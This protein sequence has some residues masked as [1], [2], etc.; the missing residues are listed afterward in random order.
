MVTTDVAARAPSSGAAGRTGRAAIA[1]SVVALG[2]WALLLV[3]ARLWG[4]ALLDDGHV[5]RLGAPPLVGWDDWRPS[6]RLLAP[7][8]AAALVV[9]V[10]PRL[11]SRR[12]WRVV[13][14]GAVAATAL[15]A[16]AL[17]LVDG[18]EGIT[19][20]LVLPGD[21]Y[22]LD[23]PSVGS[24]GDFL[25]SFTDEIDGY[26][27]HVRSHPPGML[28]L[29]WSM[30]RIGLGGTGWAAVLC[31]GGG[32]MAVAAVLVAL[33]D[34]AGER[35]ARAAAPFVVL[36]PAALWIATTADA[37]FAGVGAWAVTLLVLATGR[38]DGRG[39]L[40]A[41]G[42]GLLFG[43]ALM[44]SY[45]L[46]LLALL[47]GAVALHRRRVRPLV[48]GAVAA[49]AVLAAF[50]VAGFWW[51]E[52]L[53]VTRREYLESVARTR[54][55]RYFVVANL[56]AF[57]L[58]LGPAVAVG[59]ARLREARVWLLVGAALV[60]VVVADLSGMSKGEVERIWLPF[61]L[62]VLP[63]GVALAVRRPAVAVRGWLA[64][65]AGVALLVQTGVRT[66]W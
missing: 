25:A 4:R 34:V 17:A 54:P 41:V 22:L 35:L 64:L 27:T 45:G 9:L 48:L 49:V 24:A 33:R 51:P 43:A 11:A 26:V 60:A 10:G 40:Y 21:E 18:V 42:S 65:Q 62:W 31:I 1:W 37:F 20:P 59:L 36:A 30:D 7:L 19:R 8:A 61:A 3:V 44:L 16:V 53:R 12:P 14:A 38:R 23:V 66:R 39:D 63:A 28:L 52:G 13:L 46:V 29:L 55:F 5:L 58:A 47:P 56:A 50:A 57:G 32:A 6:V 15:W 2:A